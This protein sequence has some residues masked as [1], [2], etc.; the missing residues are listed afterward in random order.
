MALFVVPWGLVRTAHAMAV[1]P[2]DILL[3]K[4]R[5]SRALRPLR[6]TEITLIGT[7]S[8]RISADHV[9]Q[10]GVWTRHQPSGHEIFTK[11]NER[12]ELLDREGTIRW[13]KM[14]E[15]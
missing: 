12:M 2:G 14:K 9:V 11:T 8:L 3:F 15:L 4:A 13:M 1:R 7:G 6:V 10:L 5:E